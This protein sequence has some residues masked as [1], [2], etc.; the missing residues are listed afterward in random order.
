MILHKRF[1]AAAIALTLVVL[2]LGRSAQADVSLNLDQCYQEQT[3]W[4]WAGVTQSVL[5]FY[6]QNLPQTTIAAYGTDGANEWNWLHG[7]STNPTRRGINMIL[8][9]F[10]GVNS[11]IYLYALSA[12]KAESLMQENRPIFIRWG[13]DSG[14][15]H[16]VVPKAINGSNWTLMDPWYGPTINTYSWV[17]SGSGHAWTHS[18]SLDSGAPQSPK[19]SPTVINN[20]GTLILLFDK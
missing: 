1:L 20:P 7:E 9:H 19:K 11:T 17:V 15:G 5:R 6:G 10:A 4:C 2:G 3:Q 8:E 14:G 13:W 16:F 12:G 18:L